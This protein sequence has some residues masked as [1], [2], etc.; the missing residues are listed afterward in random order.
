MYYCTLCVVSELIDVLAPQGYI[1]TNMILGWTDYTVLLMFATVG[2][3]HVTRLYLDVFK[4]NLN[5]IR[6]FLQLLFG[7]QENTPLQ[8]H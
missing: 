5:N 7:Y 2:Q 4:D 8:L 3:Q 1:Y 6:S